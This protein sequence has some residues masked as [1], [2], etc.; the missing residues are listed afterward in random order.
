MDIFHHHHFGLTE[1]SMKW[2]PVS[3]PGDW[4]AGAWG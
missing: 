1:P 3:F 2:V 4:A